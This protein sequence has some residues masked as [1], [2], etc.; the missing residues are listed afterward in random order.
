MTPSSPGR[1][2]PVI[3]RV[4]DRYH[5]LVGRTKVQTLSRLAREA[6]KRSCRIS[7]LRLDKLPKNPKGAPLPVNG[8]YW[9]LTHKSE[10]VG[11]VAAPF[12][13]GLDLE[14]V[15]PVNSTMMAKVANDGEWKLVEGDR[16]KNFFRLWTAKEA[17]LKAVGHGIVG[18][19]RCRVVDVV[20]D[21]LMVL[22]YDGVSWPVESFWRNDLVAAATP[23]DFLVQWTLAT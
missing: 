18:L 9:S 23:C 10:A 1:L 7:G 22:E 20:D 5:P 11:A 6:L 8:V 4:P 3:A 14:M 12:P 16:L 13:V 2:F 19:S 21:A 15:H 17:V